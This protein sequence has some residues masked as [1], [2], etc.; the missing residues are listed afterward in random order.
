MRRLFYILVIAIVIGYVTEP[1]FAHIY[2]S[3]ATI[4][5]G[6]NAYLRTPF[7]PASAQLNTE[8]FIDGRVQRHEV[9]F[10]PMIGWILTPNVAVR[11]ATGASSG[12]VWANAISVHGRHRV[13]L[14]VET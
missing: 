8:V 7:I 13:T 4:W 2:R 5:P 10:G 12:P 9:D 3:S 14:R 6:H 1:A 11:V